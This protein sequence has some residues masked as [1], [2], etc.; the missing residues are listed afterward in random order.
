MRAASHRQPNSIGTVRI[1][2]EKVQVKVDCKCNVLMSFM[3]VQIVLFHSE[4]YLLLIKA[5][6]IQ[7]LL[8][9]IL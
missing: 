5:A 6:I 9:F 7:V 8:S 4:L 1:M 2:P 3:T